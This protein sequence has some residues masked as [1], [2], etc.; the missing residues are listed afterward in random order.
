VLEH[1][2][3]VRALAKQGQS[4]GCETVMELGFGSCNLQVQVPQVGKLQTAES[5]VGKNVATSFDGLAR[6]YF[7]KLEAK[8]LQNGDGV[9]QGPRELRTKII[10]LSGSVEAACAM[11]VAD[12]IVDLVGELHFSSCVTVKALG[13][14]ITAALGVAANI[15]LQ[16]PERQCEQQV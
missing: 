2:A 14:Q 8:E 12:G 6:E 3:R 16:N 4:G 13:S 1:D 10:E 9:S 7:A 5:L 15:A 11:G